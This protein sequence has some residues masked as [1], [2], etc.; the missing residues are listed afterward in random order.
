MQKAPVRSLKTGPSAT[1]LFKPKRPK[2]DLD[3]AAKVIQAHARKRMRQRLLAGEVRL[4][5]QKES[6]QALNAY[7]AFIGRAV[8]AKQKRRE[9]LQAEQDAKDEAEVDEYNRQKAQ[10]AQQR[11][12]TFVPQYPPSYYRGAAAFIQRR[13][14]QKGLAKPL[15]EMPQPFLPPHRP[16]VPNARL[17]KA[18]LAIQAAQRGAAVRRAIQQEPYAQT[19]QS[20]LA[21]SLSGAGASL[22]GGDGT[23]S[24]APSSSSSSSQSNHQQQEEQQQQQQTGQL[25]QQPQPQP[26]SQPPQKPKMSP[27][28]AAAAAAV[29]NTFSLFSPRFSPRASPRQRYAP[30]NDED[31]ANR[32]SNSDEHRGS[33]IPA[34]LTTSAVQEPAPSKSRS[35]GGFDSISTSSS[36]SSA[37]SGHIPSAAAKKVAA[38]NAQRQLEAEDSFLLADSS[39][40]GF[41][42]EAELLVLFSNL[43]RKYDG[44]HPFSDT[45]L[46][47]YLTR[48]RKEP[49]TPLN[50]EFDAFVSVYNGLL[51]AQVTG[52]LKRQLSVL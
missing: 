48:L 27:R 42:D 29:T 6:V 37:A 51:D 50:L 47:R 36:S 20:L 24:T 18:V 30:S 23:S 45:V 14:R 8:R 21:K 52:E 3:A 39:G 43:L 22:T 35:S 44:N 28:A 25:E 38:L 11:L 34:T 40:D 31:G 12:V 26:Q 17:R 13:A 5:K 9:A 7:A 2:S 41:V 46:A 15:A 33:L 1:Q 4:F 19:K 10:Q 32:A 16:V 49:S